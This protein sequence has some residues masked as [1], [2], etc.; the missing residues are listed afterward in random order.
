[1]Q[2]PAKALLS[3]TGPGPILLKLHEQLKQPCSTNRIPTM[4]NLEEEHGKSV[5]GVMHLL[6]TAPRQ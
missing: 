6:S 5:I 2:A 4:F 3:K 1:M